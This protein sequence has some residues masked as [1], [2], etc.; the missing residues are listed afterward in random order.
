MEWYEDS[1]HVKP[2][3]GTG[4]TP[5][6]KQEIYFIQVNG[7]GKNMNTSIIPIFGPKTNLDLHQSNSKASPSTSIDSFLAFE[8]QKDCIRLRPDNLI[9]QLARIPVQL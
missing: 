4:N 5:S 1:A 9:L 7:G 6:T 8:A 3:A 2:I